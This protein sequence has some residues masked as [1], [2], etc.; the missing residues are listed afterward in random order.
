MLT[1]AQLPPGLESRQNG[2]PLSRIRQGTI[3]CRPPLLCTVSDTTLRINQGAA[4]DLSCVGCVSDAEIVGVSGSKVTGAVPSATALATNPTDCTTGQYAKSIDAQG[5]L[6]CEAPAGGSTPNVTC[7]A[8]EALTWNGSA[9]GCVAKVRAAY[10]AD[11][12]ITAQTATHATTADSASTAGSAD[13]ANSATALASDPSDCA[14][15]QYATTIAASGNLT[16][17]Q[18]AYSQVSGTPSVPTVL[19]VKTT[20]VTNSTTTPATITGLSWS[21]TNGTEYGFRCTLLWQGTATSLTRL[22]ISGPAVT[23]AAFSTRRFTTTSAQTLLVLQALSATAQTAACTT[24]CNA[25]VLPVQIEGAILPSADGTIA[26]QVASSTA[27]Q[28]VTVF[29]GSHCEVF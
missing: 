23:H 16:C 15:G 1:L 8:D 2:R 4:S 26:L 12:G 3:D 11:A 28:T 10:Y 6:T 14:A 25:T 29:R 9:W 24:S 13:T 21:A 7:A 17:A 22:N 20:N 18:V 5:N 27:G 19:E